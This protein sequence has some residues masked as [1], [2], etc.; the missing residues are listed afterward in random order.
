MPITSLSRSKAR[1]RSWALGFVRSHGERRL[2][3]LVARFPALRQAAPNWRAEA[4]LPAGPWFDLFR[5]RCFDAA[6]PLSEWLG[7]IPFAVLTTP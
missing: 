2:A 7:L 3:V 6:A 4:E 1:R 5:G